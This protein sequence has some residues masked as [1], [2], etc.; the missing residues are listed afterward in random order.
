MSDEYNT[1]K[2]FGFFISLVAGLL[3]IHTTL[4]KQ[5]C[6]Q[7]NDKVAI[8]REQLKAV[9]DGLE[10]ERAAR[11]KEIN[12]LL[13]FF[14]YEFKDEIDRVQETMKEHRSHYAQLYEKVGSVEKSIAAIAKG[15][16]SHIENQAR[17][18]KIYHNGRGKNS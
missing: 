17:I 15:L 7:I 3:G 4:R 9:S 14:K 1:I 13:D 18:C 2:I 11:T 10:V 12:G 6:N 16:E 5:V 8:V